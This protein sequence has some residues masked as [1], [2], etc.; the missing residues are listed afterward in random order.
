[1]KPK[2]QKVNEGILLR[3]FS[4]FDLIKTFECG[5]C[6]RWEA[7]ESGVYTGIAFG[8]ILKLRK[9]S[10]DI[11]IS[12]CAEDFENIWYDYFDLSRDYKK[13][14]QFLCTDEFM[15][16]TTAFGAGIHILKQ[17]KWEALC[18][19]I[20]S[21]NNNIPRIKKIID[22]LCVS[23]GKRFFFEDREFYTFPQAER[24]ASLTVEDLAP[25]RSGYRANYILDAAKSVAYGV[26]DLDLLSSLSPYEAKAALMKLHGVGAKVADCML[27]FG[28]HMLDAFP[29]DVWVERAIKN[30]YGSSFDPNIFSPYAG[31]AQQYIFNYVRNL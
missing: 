7:D 27:L 23:F 19:F 21:Q 1:M 6:F 26:I 25:L 17:D 18:S 5:Q 10:S 13:I 30:Y 22:T 20:I 31:I 15:K 24:L 28:L 14:R 2:Y 12:C 9:S 4:D 16:K 29:R 8:R 11:I 3:D